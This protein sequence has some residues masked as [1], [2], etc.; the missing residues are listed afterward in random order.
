MFQ[1]QFIFVETKVSYLTPEGK[2]EKSNWYVNSVEWIWLDSLF[3]R[4]FKYYLCPFLWLAF[5]FNQ[6]EF[7]SMHEIKMRLHIKISRSCKLSFDCICNIKIQ[8]LKKL[9]PLMTRQKNRILK[10]PVESIDPHKGIQFMYCPWR[11]DD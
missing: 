9:S 2:R 11:C 3:K 6:F 4:G 8:L 1:I 7:F 10:I 5:L